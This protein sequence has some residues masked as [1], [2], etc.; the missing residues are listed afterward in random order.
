MYKN[1]YLEAFRQAVKEAYPVLEAN[2]DTVKITLPVTVKADLSLDEYEPGEEVLTEKW[3]DYKK[4]IKNAIK[5]IPADVQ[6][7]DSFEFIDIHDVTNFRI[8]YVDAHH[9]VV[10]YRISKYIK[11]GYENS[12]AVIEAEGAII[13]DV[14]E[15]FGGSTLDLETPEEIVTDIEVPSEHV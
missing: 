14:M 2:E 1:K 10:S 5:D 3:M 12:D 11:K 15:Q 8:S 6:L 7:D 13:N 9:V 4:I